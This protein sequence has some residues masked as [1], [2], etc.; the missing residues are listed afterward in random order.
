MEWRPAGRSPRSWRHILKAKL[1][2]QT[3]SLT[4]ESRSPRG[5]STCNG[6]VAAR[7]WLACGST[8]MNRERAL[9]IVLEFVGLIFLASVYPLVIFVR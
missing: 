5:G 4:L 6:V 2:I 3:A 7:G 9:K 8:R 1:Y